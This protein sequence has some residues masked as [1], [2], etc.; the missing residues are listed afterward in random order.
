LDFGG[1]YVCSRKIY[2]YANALPE[3]KQQQLLTFAE[4]LRARQFAFDEAKS[5]AKSAKSMSGIWSYLTS[6]ITK[7]DLNLLR[8]EMR[9]GFP[10]NV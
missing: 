1:I 6:N 5:S 10:R 9:Q 3:D 4:F 2:E 8:K 7:D